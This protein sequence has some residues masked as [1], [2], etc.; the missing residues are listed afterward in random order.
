MILRSLTGPLKS[1]V[2]SMRP[3]NFKRAA[4]IH[5]R[6]HS[7]DTIVESLPDLDSIRTIHYNADLTYN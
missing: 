3:L 1:I 2:R 6:S 5:D 7:S 4:Y